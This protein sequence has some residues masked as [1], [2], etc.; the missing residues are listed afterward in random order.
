MRAGR[1]RPW[2]GGMIALSV[3]LVAS[4]P[5]ASA[6][7]R[8][9]APPLMPTQVRIVRLFDGLGRLNPGTRLLSFATGTCGSGSIA[10]LRGDAWRCIAGNS[11]MDPCFVDPSG[12]FPLLLCLPAPW[13][14]SAVL[15]RLTAP[16]PQQYANHGTPGGPFPWSL[17]LSTGDQCTLITGATTTLGSLR[18]NYGCTATTSVYGTVL[19]THQPWTVLLWRGP[20]P[21]P[22]RVSQLTRVA[23]R[24]AWY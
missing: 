12:R 16:L 15:F 3:A 14:S 20:G 6:A 19:R 5:H 7:P 8:G 13:A 21:A 24:V 9:A 1:I 2:I 4:A 10:D 11:L 22:Q 18:L 23:V 17:R